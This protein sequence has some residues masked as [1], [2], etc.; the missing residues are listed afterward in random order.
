MVGGI[1]Y[2]TIEAVRRFLD[3]KPAMA[4]KADSSLDDAIEE[5]LREAGL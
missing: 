3:A 5:A 4:S 2:T 1:R